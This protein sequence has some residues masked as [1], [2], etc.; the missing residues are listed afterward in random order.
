[1][2]TKLPEMSEAPAGCEVIE[3][4]RHAYVCDP[5][6]PL[7]KGMRA[8]VWGTPPRSELRPAAEPRRLVVVGVYQTVDAFEAMLGRVRLAH[9]CGPRTGWEYVT[10]ACP[11]NTVAKVVGILARKPGRRPRVLNAEL[12]R[13][14]AR[15]M[16]AS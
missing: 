2:T 14:L 6:A 11:P 7:Q 16:R 15:P 9:W 5:A 10:Y 13:F 8:A 12:Q 4:G 1:M 3:F